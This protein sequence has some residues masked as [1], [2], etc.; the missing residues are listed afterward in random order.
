[1][2]VCTP[3]AALRAAARSSSANANNVMVTADAGIRKLKS[4]LFLQAL[5]HYLFRRRGRG[6]PSVL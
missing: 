2:A 4:D 6:V 3:P 1:M 5:Y